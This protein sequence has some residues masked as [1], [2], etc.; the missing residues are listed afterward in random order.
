MEKYPVLVDVLV[1]IMSVDVGLFEASEEAALFTSLSNPAYRDKL[2]KELEAALVDP[3]FSWRKLLDNERYFVFPVDSEEEGKGYVL[4]SLW[5]RI[6]S[7][8]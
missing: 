4:G 3:Q 1:S 7:M 6:F 8:D 5:S 2:Y